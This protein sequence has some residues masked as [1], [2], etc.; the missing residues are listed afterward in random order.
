MKLPDYNEY[1][2]LNRLLIA[3]GVKTIPTVP[4]VKFERTRL[5]E[6]ANQTFDP[7]DVEMECSECNREDDTVA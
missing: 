4:S 5:V 7:I 3:M 1:A 6:S 2:E